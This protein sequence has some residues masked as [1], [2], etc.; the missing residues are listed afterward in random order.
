M[1][2]KPIKIALIVFAA[3]VV[4]F[5]L[6]F[7]SYESPAKF[8]KTPL[9]YLQN[10]ETGEPVVYYEDLFG[11]T[12]EKGKVRVRIYFAHSSGSL[13]NVPLDMQIISYENLDQ[14]LA[15]KEAE[16]SREQSSAQ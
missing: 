15:Q 14:A 10:T 2:K 5:F 11:N 12:F 3:A 9:G 16:E 6:V 4:V 1:K 7:M 13:N 8:N